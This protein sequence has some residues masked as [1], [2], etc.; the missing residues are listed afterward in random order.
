[1]LCPGL[2][3]ISLT[4]NNSALTVSPLHFYRQIISLPT[5]HIN[6]RAG[7]FIKVC[8]KYFHTFQPYL[9]DFVV[10]LQHHRSIWQG[11]RRHYG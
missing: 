5:E 2:G 4:D 3:L 8:L 11:L 7:I 10:S 6:N 1:M 9:Q